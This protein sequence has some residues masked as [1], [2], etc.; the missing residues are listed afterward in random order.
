MR[1]I[2]RSAGTMFTA[3][4]LATA[5]APAAGA[6][7]VTEHS[8][9]A[10]VRAQ[11]GWDEGYW[12][13][14]AAN[15]QHITFTAVADNRYTAKKDALAACGNSPRTESPDSCHIVSNGFYGREY[16][17]HGHQ[18]DNGGR[19]PDH[20]GD[21]P[22]EHRGNDN[23]GH[24]GNPGG[25]WTPGGTGNPTHVGNPGRRRQPGPLREPGRHRQP[26][27][28]REPGRPRDPRRHRQRQRHPLREPRR[29]RQ[30]HPLREPRRHQQRQPCPLREPGRHRGPRRHRQPDPLRE[31]GRHRDP[32]AAPA[33]RPTSATQAVPATP[34]PRSGTLHRSPAVRTLADRLQRS[35]RSDPVHRSERPVPGP[36]SASVDAAWA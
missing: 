25:P 28:L 12:Q 4:A 24:A 26:G 21:R 10:L 19:F 11:N 14:V 16:N 30:P 8:P 2:A 34:P 9:R 22:G 20:Q 13:A 36:L 6:A 3:A 15:S 27:P 33:T 31:P 32:R 5:F 35:R 1:N 17:D 18:F 23:P 7:T 29:H